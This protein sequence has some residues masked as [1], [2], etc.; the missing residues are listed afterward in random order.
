MPMRYPL[1]NP[2]S[3]SP[4][5]VEA[6]IACLRS[7]RYTLGAHVEAF[8]EA[9]AQFLGVQHAVMVNSGSSANLLA[10]EAL[11]R[12]SSGHP[13]WRQG[14]RIAIP[15]LCWPTS[16]WPLVQL[17][18]R[19]VFVDVDPV[20][21][22]LDWSKVP[23]QVDGAVLIHVLGSVAARH[24]EPDFPVIEDACESFGAPTMGRCSLTTFSHFFSHQ[25]ATMEGGMV[26]T[27]N[28]H[29]ADDLRSM[30]SHGWT[31]QRS[32]RNIWEEACPTSIDPRFCFVTSGYNVRPL[33]V[34]AAM[35]LVQLQQLPEVL[36]RH[37]ET[38]AAIRQGL[39]WW[40]TFPN[41][42][43]TISWMNAPL[44]VHPDSPVGPL[45]AKVAFEV[46]GI[47]TRPILSGNFLRHPVW[48]GRGEHASYPVADRLHARGFMMG[49]WGDAG[50]AVDCLERAFASL[51]VTV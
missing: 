26:T 27:D 24:P 14:D 32:D 16:V 31:R 29:V 4:E 11:L 17:G 34:E 1:S 40:L 46:A 19:P 50:T 51:P 37:R 42:N 23:C 13:I 22:G 33:E 30:R 43:A 25:L 36:R 28:P 21:L 18:L 10:V 5:A 41:P 49:C 38:A 6:G 3:I 47:E 15:T 9:V 39:P 20:T 35:G 12:P 2:D 44:I 45:A 7:G 8:E 48:G